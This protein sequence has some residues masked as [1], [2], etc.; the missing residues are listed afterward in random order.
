MRR[1]A[2]AI[3]ESNRSSSLAT[4]RRSFGSAPTMSALGRPPAVMAGVYIFTPSGIDSE[5][6]ELQAHISPTCLPFYPSVSMAS[7]CLAPREASGVSMIHSVARRHA[8]RR[9]VGHALESCAITGRAA[10]SNVAGVTPV[11]GTARR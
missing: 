8:G 5:A 6:V 9:A 2:F 7:V 3:S 10:I 1:H 11:A 4:L